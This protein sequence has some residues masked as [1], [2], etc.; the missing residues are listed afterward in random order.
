[1]SIGQP[2][3]STLMRFPANSRLRTLP[4][5]RTCDPPSGPTNDDS[6][7]SSLFYH[8]APGVAGLSPQTR[9]LQAPRQNSTRSRE[10]AELNTST[11]L[12]RFAASHCRTATP[13]R[14]QASP[15]R[16]EDCDKHHLCQPFHPQHPFYGA[17][18]Q[19]HTVSRSASTPEP[20]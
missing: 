14:T 11:I 5:F 15:E 8:A 3:D 9:P 18:H 7:A 16:L 4:L 12:A 19:H 2:Q 1:V 17:R 6:D 20:S 10:R 13:E